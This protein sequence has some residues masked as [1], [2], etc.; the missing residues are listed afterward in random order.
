[1]DIITGIQEIVRGPPTDQTCIDLLAHY[2]DADL[3]LDPGGEQ[4]L[5]NRLMALG[6]SLGDSAGRFRGW[7]PVYDP[8]PEVEVDGRMVK[9][10]TGKRGASIRFGF[11]VDDP[12]E[13][14]RWGG[15]PPK[16]ET[17]HQ[18]VLGTTFGDLVA[19]L[20]NNSGAHLDMSVSADWIESHIP[21]PLVRTGRHYIA[22]DVII[23]PGRNRMLFDADDDAVF[24]ALGLTR[25]EA[26]PAVNYY[27]SRSS[28]ADEEARRA[29]EALRP[30]LADLV[31]TLPAT[32][33]L[34]DLDAIPWG[35]LKAAY[36]PATAVPSWL[37][38]LAELGADKDAEI[39]W[40]SDIVSH[41]GST[42]TASAFVVPFMGTLLIEWPRLRPAVLDYLSQLLNPYY[43][44]YPDQVSPADPA[45]LAHDWS[46]PAAVSVTVHRLWPTL[47]ELAQDEDTE[48][49]DAAQ[50]LMAWLGG[51]AEQSKDVFRAI[52]E[53]RRATAW[54]VLA[55]GLAGR[56]LGLEPDSINEIVAGIPPDADEPDLAK[57]TLVARC[58]LGD[59]DVG[60]D[61]LKAAHE[62]IASPRWFEGSQMR[63]T[64]DA[65]RSFDDW[66][67]PATLRTI[68]REREATGEFV[69]ND[70]LGA[71]WSLLIGRERPK[72]P[73]NLSPAA[74]R[75]LEAAADT[76]EPD[77]SIGIDATEIR[78]YLAGEFVRDL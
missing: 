16:W 27:H 55:Y 40:L 59:R 70:A 36:G 12:Y 13:H 33:P 19:R 64:V 41:Q 65:L 37:R 32:M 58:L 35:E 66:P 48:V 24:E 21:G 11:F 52:A 74:R 26:D 15:V 53:S 71:L 18:E 39:G 72:D 20:T 2:F 62:R 73:D 25:F 77:E 49:A 29:W 22:Q 5:V 47:A 7:F 34:D 75:F 63:V 30:R 78:R 4:P 8:G 1:M 67:D 57:T 60:A 76:V 69:Y 10:Y 23:R 56:T 54:T 46:S 42:Y 45:A 6:P 3:D 44:T 31:A 50:H 51:H 68:I 9:V 17:P 28:V 43:D 61:L 14:M 38:E